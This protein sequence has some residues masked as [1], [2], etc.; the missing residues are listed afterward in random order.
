MKILI[1]K[2]PRFSPPNAIVLGQDDRRYTFQ[3]Y[4]GI[5]FSLVD[6]EDAPFFLKQKRRAPGGVMISIF[7]EASEADKKILGRC[8]ELFITV[9]N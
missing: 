9:K 6:V 3:E 5:H 2:D 4:R 7:R 1:V 8:E